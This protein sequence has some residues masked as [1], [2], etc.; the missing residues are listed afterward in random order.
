LNNIGKLLIQI[1]AT[2]RLWLAGY[3]R[4]ESMAT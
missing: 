4:H 3:Q 2:I 1:I